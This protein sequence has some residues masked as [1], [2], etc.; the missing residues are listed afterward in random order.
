MRS[1]PSIRRAFVALSFVLGSATRR[2]F[3][4]RASLLNTLK[5]VEIIMARADRL[6]S[7]TFVLEIKAAS[8]RA[9]DLILCEFIPHE[10][11]FIATKEQGLT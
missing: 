8:W 5:I 4:S 11:N 1:A 7:P 10:D 9:R 6:T 3:S 2:F